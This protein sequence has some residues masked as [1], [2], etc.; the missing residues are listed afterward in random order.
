MK[1][2]DF[3]ILPVAT[4]KHDNIETPLAHYVGNLEFLGDIRKKFFM[5]PTIH[6]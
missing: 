3:I 6:A 5:C 1:K 4:I 2:S